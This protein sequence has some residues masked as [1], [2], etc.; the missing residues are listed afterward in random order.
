M[1]LR[2]RLFKETRNYSWFQDSSRADATTLAMKT[3]DIRKAGINP[4][5]GIVITIE[6]ADEP[7]MA[8]AAN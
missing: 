6:E 3:S 5:Y 1:K 4:E 8:E 7:I 2:L